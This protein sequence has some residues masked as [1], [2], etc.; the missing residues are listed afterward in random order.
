MPRGGRREGAGGR[1]KWRHGKTKT[2]RVP[3]VLVNQ[4]LEY[5]QK[6][7]IESII[8]HDTRSKVVTRIPVTGNEALNVLNL[9][10]ISIYRNQQKSFVFLQDLIKLGY[11]IE[12]KS[13]ADRILEEIYKSQIKQ[14]NTNNGAEAKRYK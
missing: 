1:F 9:S 5:A 12:P 2:I 10:G 3:E 13:L 7:D 14:G 11:E 8:E 4:I 6:L